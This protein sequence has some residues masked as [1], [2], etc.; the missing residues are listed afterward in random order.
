VTARVQP[1][2]ARILALLDN[3]EKTPAWL[4]D[5]SKVERSTVTRAI[6]G[7]RNPSPKTLRRFAQSLGVTFAELVTGTDASTDDGVDSTL[8]ELELRLSS[9][10]GEAEGLRTA[11]RILRDRGGSK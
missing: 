3:L 7:E 8:E 5:K 11:I 6:N 1:I 9:V 10:L 4:A 2:G